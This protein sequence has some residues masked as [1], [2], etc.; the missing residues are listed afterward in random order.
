[1][2]YKLHVSVCF[3][4]FSSLTVKVGLCHESMT[5]AFIEVAKLLS[6]ALSILEQVSSVL[7]A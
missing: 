2:K 7:V 1:M 3:L 4:W 6:F 5:D